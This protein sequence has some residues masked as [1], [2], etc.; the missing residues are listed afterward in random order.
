MPQPGLPVPMPLALDSFGPRPSHGP[1]LDLFDLKE[2]EAGRAGR[3]LAGG[4]L[5][6]GQSDPRQPGLLDSSRARERRGGG[7]FQSNYSPGWRAT[8]HSP[9]ESPRPSGDSWLSELLLVKPRGHY[10][11]A[12]EDRSEEKRGQGPWRARRREVRLKEGQMDLSVCPASSPL[13]Q[14]TGS[15]PGDSSLTFK[16]FCAL[17]SHRFYCLLDYIEKKIRKSALKI[18]ILHAGHVW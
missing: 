11:V 14:N 3:G 1:S 10:L 9:E 12:Q 15:Q 2:R 5:G 13:P 6:Q 18:L 7:K 16:T 8:K 17:T 4:D